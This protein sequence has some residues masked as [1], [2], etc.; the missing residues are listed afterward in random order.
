MF[1]QSVPPIS[2]EE[3][4]VLIARGDAIVVDVREAYEVARTGK[5]AGALHVPSGEIASR[6]FDRDKALILYCAAGERSDIS[7]RILKSRGY[8][9][10]YNL[11]GFRD[12]LASGG[13]IEK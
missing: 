4:K 11:G 5:V 8:P 12:W 6:D 1:E 7:G 9:T 10:V 3:A 2:P 13:A